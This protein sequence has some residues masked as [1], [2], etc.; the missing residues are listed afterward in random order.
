MNSPQF[1]ASP[2]GP[3]PEQEKIALLDKAV[4]FFYREL[5]QLVASLDADQL[6]EFLIRFQEAVVRQ[7]A[8]HRLSIPARLECFRAIPQ[9]V[10]RLVEKGPELATAA[11]SRFLIEYV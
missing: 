6:L 10:R 7:T 1:R 9:M 8:F 11:A 4:A 2:P 5:V 3:I